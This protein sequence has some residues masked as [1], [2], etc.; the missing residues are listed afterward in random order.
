MINRRDENFSILE[1]VSLLSGF[2]DHYSSK[3]FTAVANSLYNISVVF[4]KYSNGPKL[5]QE[6]GFSET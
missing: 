3:K 5:L 1:L 6:I 2:E 4:R